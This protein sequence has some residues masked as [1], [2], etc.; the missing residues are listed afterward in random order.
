MVRSTVNKKGI[1][2][3]MVGELEGPI[4]G[5]CVRVGLQVCVLITLP[6]SVL[7]PELYAQL[8]YSENI[9]FTF[10]M[11]LHSSTDNS[12][13]CVDQH[14]TMNSRTVFASSLCSF[15]HAVHEDP[16]C[17]PL[18]L[19]HVRILRALVLHDVCFEHSTLH[20]SDVL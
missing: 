4:V 8:P 7:V 9:R 12:A 20:V 17:T 6:N 13:H 16:E 2:V 10:D 14:F 1:A 5:I 11:P 15:S 18:L 19:A 3:P